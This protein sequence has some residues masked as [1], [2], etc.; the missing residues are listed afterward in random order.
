MFWLNYKKWSSSHGNY[1]TAERIY[2]NGWKWSPFI[3]IKKRY[4]KEKS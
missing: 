3:W 1:F 4:K 2:L